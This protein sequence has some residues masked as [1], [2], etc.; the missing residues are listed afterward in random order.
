VR[1][2]KPRNLAAESAGE[3]A[4]RSAATPAALESAVDAAVGSAS[5]Q[6]EVSGASLAFAELTTVSEAAQLSSA[7]AGETASPSAE[8]PDEELAPPPA[9]PVLV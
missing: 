3:R 9:R 2:G 7:D 5:Q 8:L 1:G 4:A 6:Q